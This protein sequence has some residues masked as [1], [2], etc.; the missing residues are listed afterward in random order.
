MDFS[1]PQLIGYLTKL[2]YMLDYNVPCEF[3]RIV[4]KINNRRYFAH[5]GAKGVSLVV[6]P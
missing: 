6:S 5:I 1:I 2:E 4:R 3:G